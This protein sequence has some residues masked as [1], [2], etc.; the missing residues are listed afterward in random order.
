MTA[1]RALFFSSAFFS[2]CFSMTSRNG[3]LCL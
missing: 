3:S 2:L 1:T